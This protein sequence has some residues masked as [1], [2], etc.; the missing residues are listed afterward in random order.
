MIKQLRT[1]L[2]SYIENKTWY[3]Y[4]PAWLFGLYL[5][6][7]ILEFK[8]GEPAGFIISIPQAFD[9]FLHE[10]AHLFFGFLP[11]VLVAAA[12]SFAELFLGLALIVVAFYTRSYFA[13]LFCVLWFMLATQSVTDYIA[14]ARSQS[15][16]L[17]SFGGSDPI[18]D[19]NFILEK[20]GLLEYD[21]LIAGLLSGFGIICG[22]IA[23]IFSGWL[24]IRFFVNQRAQVEQA[25]KDTLMNEIIKNRP[26]DRPTDP[27]VSESLYPGAQRGPLADHKKPEDTP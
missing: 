14:D 9:F 15:L 18:H 16:P 19:W 7:Q 20:L 2:E 17:V 27:F 24:I 26:K 13:S 6:M 12:G 11:H 4:I 8:L 3:W 23:L 5:F 22:I 10:M 1:E 25:R 21:T